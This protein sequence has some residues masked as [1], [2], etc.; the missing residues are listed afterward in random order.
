GPAK[1]DVL[2]RLAAIVGAVDAIAVAD[3]ALAV[4]LAGADPDGFGVL[5]VEGDGADGVGA[6]VVEEGVPGGAGVGGLPDPARGDG[7]VPGGAVLRMNR[8][9]GNAS[10]REGRPEGAQPESADGT[11]A[12]GV[13]CGRLTR[14]RADEEQRQDEDE[15]SGADAR[16]RR[17]LFRR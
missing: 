14:Q 12:E 13:V 6:L 3:A 15:Q 9:R 5:G 2:P 7:D 11:G 10:G 1:A 16:H 17:P 4:V 8:K